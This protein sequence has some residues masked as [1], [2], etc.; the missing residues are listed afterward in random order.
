MPLVEPLPPDAD[1]SVRMTILYD[2]HPLRETVGDKY[3]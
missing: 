1:E 3:A 2:T